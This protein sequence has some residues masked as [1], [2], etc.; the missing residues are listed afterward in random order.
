MKNTIFTLI[1]M[2]GISTIATHSFAVPIVFDV[3]NVDQTG[4]IT[5]TF[6]NLTTG[7]YDQVTVGANLMNI[8]F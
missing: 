7:V 8:S 4:F 5:L 2:I 6:T 3:T 1:A